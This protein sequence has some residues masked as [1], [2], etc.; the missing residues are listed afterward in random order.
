VKYNTEAINEV[1]DQL[2]KVLKSAILEQQKNGDG[3]VQIAQVEAGMRVKVW[4]DASIPTGYFVNRFR[5]GCAN[6]R[7]ERLIFPAS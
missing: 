1:A 2:A 7:I 4:D 5:D 3:A 6:W